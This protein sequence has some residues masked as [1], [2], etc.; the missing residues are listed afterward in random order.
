MN[1]VVIVVGILVLSLAARYGKNFSYALKLPLSRM[2]D[3]SKQQLQQFCLSLKPSDRHFLGLS[4][5]EDGPSIAFGNCITYDKEA[6]IVS[7]SNCPNIQS[8]NYTLTNMRRK[9]RLPEKFTQLNDYMCDP[10]SRNGTVCSKCANGF[11]PS[12]TSL[13]YNCVS[14]QGTWYGVPLIVVWNWFQSL[15]S[16]SP[17]WCFRLALLQYLCL[18]LSCTLNLL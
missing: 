18:A 11:G 1:F 7:F 2:P 8:N 5:S 14:C 9:I 12:F 13:G 15:S 4:C 3:N 16:I 6:R 17:S 10:L